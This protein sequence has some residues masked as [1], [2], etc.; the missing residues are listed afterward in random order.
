M[1]GNARIDGLYNEALVEFNF[2]RSL[3]A[4]RI[5][6]LQVAAI[7]F[8]LMDVFCVWQRKQSSMG[9]GRVV[10]LDSHL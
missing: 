10:S 1:L 2:V 7:R 9:R 4:R 6:D 3:G 5:G 8:D